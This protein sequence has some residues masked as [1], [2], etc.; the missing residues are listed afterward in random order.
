MPPEL[1]FVFRHSPYGNSL[2]REGLEAALAA[3]AFDQNM[4]ILFLDDG[5]WQLKNQQNPSNGVRK[6]HQKMAAALPLFGVD[7]LYVD[8][9]SLNTR[10]IQRSELCV[11]TIFIT[12]IN[13]KQL[14]SNA[15]TVLSF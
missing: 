9:E 10:H 11:D 4:A 6:N 7:A 2:G 5:V 14:I 3:G 13:A 1:L 15:R 8:I 12:R